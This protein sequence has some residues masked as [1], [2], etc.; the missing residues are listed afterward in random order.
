MLTL[1][2]LIDHVP[3]HA[4]IGIVLEVK[5]DNK[6]A[7]STV[8][9]GYRINFIKFCNHQCIYPA[10]YEVTNVYSGDWE[11][12]KGLIIGVKYAEDEKKWCYCLSIYYHWGCF[13]YWKDC[14]LLWLKEK[15]HA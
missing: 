9:S 5:K 3:D 6:K 4:R 14:V 15:E 7:Y 8:Y 1:T 12:I 13:N 10:G 11:G 2:E